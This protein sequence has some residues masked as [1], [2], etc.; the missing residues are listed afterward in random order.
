MPGKVTNTETGATDYRLNQLG[1]RVLGDT[2]QLISRMGED[3][4][5]LGPRWRMPIRVPDGDRDFPYAHAISV[6]A[7]QFSQSFPDSDILTL[8]KKST[9]RGWKPLYEQPF[10]R[11]VGNFYTE[12]Q[13]SGDGERAKMLAPQ[14]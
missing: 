7:Y 9:P 4:L 5:P 10:L 2:C 3:W 8:L 13:A 14:L 1:V 12:H 6:T 11:M